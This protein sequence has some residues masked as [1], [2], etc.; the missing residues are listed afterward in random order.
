MGIHYGSFV[1]L[2]L[3]ILVVGNVLLLG[4]SRLV[5][6]IQISAVE[7][8]VVT[9]LTVALHTGEIG[10]RVLALALSSM[11]IKVGLFPWLLVR[12]VRVAHIKKEIEPIIGYAA[13]L[14]AGVFIIALSLWLAARLP[15]PGKAA[16]SFILMVA[17][18]TIFTGC[19]LIVSRTKAI[20]Q[21]IAYLVLENGVYLL[22]IPFV[23][24]A[25]FLIELGVFLDLTVGIFIMGIM[26]HQI[27][28]EFDS[29]DVKHLSQLS[30]WES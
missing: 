10:V 16:N 5:T 8:L 22:G 14:I 2:L 17:F 26:I 24:E 20:T 7:G 15:I 1:D 19:F 4:S 12:A 21:V 30:D 3:I 9:I 23:G 28:R 11:L 6:C 27:N 25:H 18:F 29:L 13:S